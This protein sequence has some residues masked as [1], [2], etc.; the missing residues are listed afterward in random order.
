MCSLDLQLHWHSLHS[1]DLH[2]DNRLIP[3]VGVK[4]LTEV[5]DD[6]QTFMNLA[7]ETYRSG[8]YPRGPR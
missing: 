1:L 7:A 4:L 3:A 5:S 8:S 2:A 6:A